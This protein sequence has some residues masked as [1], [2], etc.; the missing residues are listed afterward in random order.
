MKQTEESLLARN[1][2]CAAFSNELTLQ[3]LKEFREQFV[4]TAKTVVPNNNDPMCINMQRAIGRIDAID[5]IIARAEDA[6]KPQN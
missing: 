3:V 4:L 5:Y 2:L 6:L 1:R